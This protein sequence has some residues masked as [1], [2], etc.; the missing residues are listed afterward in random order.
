MTVEFATGN[1]SNMAGCWSFLR[2]RRRN[3]IPLVLGTTFVLF[4]GFAFAQERSSHFDQRS[5]RPDGNQP[6]TTINELRAPKAARG[7]VERAREA[8][9][10]GNFP[11]AHKQLDRV[12][13]AF[14]N[15]APALM[16]EGIV[17]AEEQNFAMA[18]QNLNAA[19]K[20][21]PSYSPAYLQLAA[22]DNDTG[23]YDDAL[24][25]L[26]RAM[27]L[28]PSSW[29]LYLELANADIGMREY[30][31][32][33][34]HIERAEAL[35][36]RDLLSNAR[37]SNTRAMMHLLKACAFV[38]IGS[39]IRARPEFEAAIEAEPNGEFAHYSRSALAQLQLP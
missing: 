29:L 15:Y 24:R 34:R 30:Q 1:L 27:P 21:D 10:K 35:Q 6:I 9:L 25:L 14:P 8:I 4:L 16:L 22:F 36:P 32:A 7:A 23:R 31:T 18:E 33:L 11:E 26:N 12:L 39:Q 3:R 17:N 28:M 19:I 37:A 5:A 2:W 38:G 20:A 13:K